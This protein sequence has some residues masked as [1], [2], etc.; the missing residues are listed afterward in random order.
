MSEPSTVTRVAPD[1]GEFPSIV[2]L[3]AGASMV[4]AAVKL[5]TCQP[6]VTATRRSV[7]IPFDMR[8]RT[9]LSDNHSVISDPDPDCLDIV[10]YCAPPILMPTTVTLTAPLSAALTAMRELRPAAS[11]VSDAVK[12]F[13][14]QPV[15]MIARRSGQ[16]GCNVRATT[17]DSDRQCVISDALP[18]SRDG[19]L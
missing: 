17:L 18:P 7:Q 5:F 1:A 8:D 6:V 11:I 10:V 16:I 9:E 19:L 14:C 3:G 12:L 2:L 15:V 13:T 4:I